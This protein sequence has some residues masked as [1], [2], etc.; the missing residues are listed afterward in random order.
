MDTEEPFGYLFGDAVKSVVGI[1]AFPIVSRI[2]RGV[3]SSKGLFMRDQGRT[4]RHH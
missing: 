3:Y 4:Q 2:A 1:R